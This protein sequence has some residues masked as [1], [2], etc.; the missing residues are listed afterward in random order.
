M[1]STLPKRRRLARHRRPPIR[2]TTRVAGCRC[3]AWRQSAKKTDAKE[4][5]VGVQVQVHH[6]H[7]AVIVRTRSHPTTARFIR[8]LALEHEEEPTHQRADVG[9]GANEPGGM[10]PLRGRPPVVSAVVA[11]QLRARRDRAQHAPERVR[12]A[13]EVVLAD[14]LDV[15]PAVPPLASALARSLVGAKRVVDVRAGAARVRVEVDLRRRRR[16]NLGLF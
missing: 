8:V 4:R 3:R 2:R 14:E 12:K 6:T 16:R 7:T 11:E 1:V 9:L 15:L 13:R 5:N 10:P